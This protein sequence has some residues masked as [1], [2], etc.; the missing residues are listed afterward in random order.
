M[1][2]FEFEKT[3]TLCTHGCPLGALC[4]LS[5]CPSCDYEFTEKPRVVSWLGR[6]L[7]RNGC[8]KEGTPAPS[9][10]DMK[11]GEW[12]LVRGVASHAD[13]QEAGN[14]RRNMLAAFGLIAGSEVQLIQRH[15]AYVVR[16][17]ETELA[18]DAE[19]AQEILIERPEVPAA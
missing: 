1:C 12:A 18:L 15:P 13:A 2:G 19:I 11:S 7:G 3:D 4:S 17:G 8:I 5:R 9:V 14:R 10:R 16:V 6:L